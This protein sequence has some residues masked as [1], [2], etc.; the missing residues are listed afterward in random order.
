MDEYLC[1]P[2]IPMLNFQGGG[3]LMNGISALVKETPEPPL[4]AFS[5]MWQGHGEKMAI[6]NPEEGF[7]RTWQC[8]HSDFQASRMV[9]HE[10]LLFI[11]ISPTAYGDFDGVDCKRAVAK[12]RGNFFHSCVL[13]KKGFPGGPVAENPPANVGNNPWGCEDLLEKG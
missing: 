1:P 11:N 2:Q 12:K 8:W 7:T 5:S 13:Y 6:W 10:F 9:R 3:T 4:A